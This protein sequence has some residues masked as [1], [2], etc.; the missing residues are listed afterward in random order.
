MPCMI[1]CPAL[2]E[3]RLAFENAVPLVGSN[4]V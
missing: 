1:G 3:P 4:G 2:K